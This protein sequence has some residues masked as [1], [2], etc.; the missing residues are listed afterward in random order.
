MPPGGR[1]GLKWT[2]GGGG[3]P[4]VP[5]PDHSQKEGL[6]TPPAKSD[7]FPMHGVKTTE[8]R[9]SCVVHG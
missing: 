1:G 2:Q 8:I 4:F 9:K 5:G 7:G 3:P 6:V